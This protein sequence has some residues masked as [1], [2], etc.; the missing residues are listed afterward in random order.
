MTEAGLEVRPVADAERSR[1]AEIVQKEWGTIEIISRGK[2]HD[3]SRCPALFCLE[4]GRIVGLA[5]Y[6]ISDHSCE[7][8]TIDA[9]EPRRGIGSHLL[10]AVAQ[11]ARAAGCRR[12]W[13]I[14]TNDNLDAI[15]FY[16]RRGMRLVAL[17]PGQWTKLA[18]S[19]RRSRRSA[20]TGSRSATSSSSSSLS[21]ASRPGRPRG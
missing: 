5:T 9:F 21:V 10:E 7:L 13:L 4:H 1:L 14:T 11:Q 17:H 15:R 18:C 20:T 6:A 16:Q 8:L 2:A 12:L 3:L 19:N